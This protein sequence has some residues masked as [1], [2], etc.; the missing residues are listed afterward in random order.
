VQAEVEFF[1]KT[2]RKAGLALQ[3]NVALD[4]IEQHLVTADGTILVDS[5]EAKT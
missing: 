2:L 5:M 1:Q 4:T 3:M